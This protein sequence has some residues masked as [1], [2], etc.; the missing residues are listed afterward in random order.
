[1]NSP[2][3]CHGVGPLAALAL[4][5]TGGIASAATVNIPP[6]E[7]STLHHVYILNP[8]FCEAFLKDGVQFPCAPGDCS[9]PGFTASIGTGDTIIARFEAP[10]GKKFVVTHAA[11]GQQFLFVNANWFTGIGD[12]QSNFVTG[13]V[14][15]ENLSGTPPVST[16][17]QNGLSNNGE[18]IRVVEQFDV[19]GDFEFTAMEVEFV[20]AHPLPS[21]PRTYLPVNSTSALSFGSSQSGTALPDVTLMTIMEIAPCPADI[22]GDG[23]VGIGD[24]LM[25][26]G[27][28]GPCP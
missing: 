12:A 10:A 5:S 28:W 2:R 8:V 22:D 25:V 6:V 20:I 11:A 13:I 7:V 15:F 17:S 4:L 16:F 9:G 23:E 26:L 24:F 27:L 18:N 3:T 19:V 14:T 21:T 1:M